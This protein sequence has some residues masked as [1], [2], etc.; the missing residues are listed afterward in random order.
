MVIHLFSAD[1]PNI[2]NLTSTI[3]EDWLAQVLKSTL[4]TYLML[5]AYSLRGNDSGTKETYLNSF[6]PFGPNKHSS[7]NHLIAKVSPAHVIAIKRI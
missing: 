3:I 7:L 6:Q 4:D 2:T 5:D 1:P